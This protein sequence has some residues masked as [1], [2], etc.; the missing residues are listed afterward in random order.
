MSQCVSKLLPT[1]VELDIPES[2]AVCPYCRSKLYA[3]FQCW[4]Q[5]DE[6]QWKADEIHLDCENINSEKIDHYYMPYVHQ[7]PVDLKCLEWVNENYSF[8]IES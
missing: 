2:V 4:T 5:N 1:D 7:M 6:G 3:T 8:D